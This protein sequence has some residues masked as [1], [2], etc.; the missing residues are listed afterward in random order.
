MRN[1]AKKKLRDKKWHQKNR[2]YLKLYLRKYR[3]EHPNLY[4][5][6]IESERK[7]YERVRKKINDLLGS[8]CKIC[9]STCNLVCHEIHGKRHSTNAN[10]ILIH[11]EDFVRLCSQCHRMVHY[12]AKNKNVNLEILI[13]FKSIIL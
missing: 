11:I 8:K 3:K 12:L 4:W 9:G 2:E 10:Y 5:K 1:L 7:T 6:Y 13:R